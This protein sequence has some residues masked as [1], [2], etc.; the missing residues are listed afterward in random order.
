MKSIANLTGADFLR[1]CNRIR[2]QAAFLLRETGVMEIRKRQPE[3]TGEETAEEKQAKL[4]AQSKANLDAMLDKLLDEKAEE[5]TAL[6]SL[7]AVPE[8]GDDE[9]TGLD[10]ALCGM[11]ILTNQKVLDF[12]LSLMKLDLTSM[13]G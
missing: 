9:M 7:L 12:L 3:L 8:D 1:Q 13:D 10:L 2:K 4:K 5:T 11:E 6:I